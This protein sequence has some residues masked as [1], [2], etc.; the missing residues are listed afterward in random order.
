MTVK[1]RTRSVTLDGG[2][3]LYFLKKKKKKFRQ[4]VRPNEDKSNLKKSPAATRN[5]LPSE[6]I[7]LRIA[8][9]ALI[10]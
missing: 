5:R 4:P 9:D 6:S 3:V 10:L 7:D 1:R 2:P 8:N